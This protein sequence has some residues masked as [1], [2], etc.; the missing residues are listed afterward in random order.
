VDCEV[1]HDL[2]EQ[3]ELVLGQAFCMQEPMTW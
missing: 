2:E 3:F 1:V